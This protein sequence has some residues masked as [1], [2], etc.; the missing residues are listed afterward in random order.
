MAEEKKRKRKIKEPEL[1][2]SPEVE[3]L[4]PTG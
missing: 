1:S 2:Q 3:E 4:A